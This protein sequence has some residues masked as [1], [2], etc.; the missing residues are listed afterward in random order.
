MYF[1]RFVWKGTEIIHICPLQPNA[2]HQP[3]LPQLGS[4]DSKDGGGGTVQLHKVHSIYF[5][6]YII[7]RIEGRERN[8]SNLGYQ[9]STSFLCSEYLPFPC[10]FIKGDT[11]VQEFIFQKCK[12]NLKGMKDK[13]YQDAMPSLR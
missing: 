5:I 9:R 1:N 6:P 7:M 3:T 13:F 8:R 2:C 12:R 10:V 11:Q 4:W